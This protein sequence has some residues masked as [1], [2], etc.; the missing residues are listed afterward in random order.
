MVLR[1][2]QGPY[3]LV[4][5]LF[6]ILLCSIQEVQSPLVFD[7]GH[8]FALHALQGNGASSVGEGEVS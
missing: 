6:G 7:V 2:L 3:R 1:S 4:T 5:V 8:G